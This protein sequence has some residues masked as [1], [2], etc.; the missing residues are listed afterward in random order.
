LIE[1]L[2]RNHDGRPPLNRV[3]KVAGY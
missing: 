3:D 1:N 2:R